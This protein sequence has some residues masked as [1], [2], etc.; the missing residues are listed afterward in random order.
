M[1]ALKKGKGL[2]IGILLGKGPKGPDTEEDPMD[3]SM[4]DTSEEDTSEDEEE[5]PPGLVEAVTEF[6][7][8]ESDE[9]AAKAF[10][11]AIQLCQEI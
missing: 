2:T 7:T 10:H 3:E 4:D 9:D 8:S 5:L 1:P 11:R 6:R